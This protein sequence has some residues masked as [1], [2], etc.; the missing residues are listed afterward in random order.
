MIFHAYPIQ[1]PYYKDNV[2][3]FFHAYPV[4]LPHFNHEVLTIFSRQSCP[5][6]IS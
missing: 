2:L 6:A 3:T 4:S 5:N 1:L